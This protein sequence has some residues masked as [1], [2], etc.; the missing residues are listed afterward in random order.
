MSYTDSVG[1]TQKCIE[2]ITINLLQAADKIPCELLLLIQLTSHLFLGVSV[3]C[4]MTSVD[5]QICAEC[6]L[7]LEMLSGEKWP[8]RHRHCVDSMAATVCRAHNRNT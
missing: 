8:L 3:S 7:Y 4:T 1:Q 2:N 6:N 5:C